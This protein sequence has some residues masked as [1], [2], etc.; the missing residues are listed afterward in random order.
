MLESGEIIPHDS[1][2]YLVRLKKAVPDLDDIVLIYA[3]ESLQCYLNGNLMASS[4]M[5]GVASEAAF[6]RL[7][8]AFKNSVLIDARVKEKA[9]KLEKRISVTDKFNL[10]YD[11]ITRK[12]GDL[13]TNLAEVIEYNLNGI[14]N[15][16]RLQ[17]NESGHPTGTRPDKDQ[18]FANLTIFI[19]YCKTLYELLKW[20][21]L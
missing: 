2:D 7:L 18:M 13:D 14:F 5:L 19:M 15:L 9:E 3:E 21:E 4:V 17:R 12:K 20:L 6:Y 8:E 10:V 1:Y 16:I 11:E